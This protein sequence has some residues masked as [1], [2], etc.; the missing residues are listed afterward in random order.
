MAVT[1]PA[2]ELFR[3]FNLFLEQVDINIIVARGMHLF[4][5]HLSA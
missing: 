4:K 1:Q 5:F 3:V 2:R